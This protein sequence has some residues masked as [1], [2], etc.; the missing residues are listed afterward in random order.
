MESHHFLIN[1]GLT[2]LLM[3]LIAINTICLVRRTRRLEIHMG[4]LPRWVYD[5]AKTQPRLVEV[6]FAR[7]LAK[8]SS[9]TNF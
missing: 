4:D 8:P 7:A 1:S 2:A 3:L 9:N 6:S 5:Y